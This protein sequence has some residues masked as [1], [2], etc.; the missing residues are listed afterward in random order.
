MVQREWDSC[1]NGRV[2][3]I[4]EHGSRCK[5]REDGVHKGSLVVGI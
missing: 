2:G 4:W 5:G 1:V 3:N